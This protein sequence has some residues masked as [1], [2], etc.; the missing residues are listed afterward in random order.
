[1]DEAT[2]RRTAMDSTMLISLISA[3]SVGLL[4]LTRLIIVFDRE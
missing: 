3:A 2:L 4:S 1:M